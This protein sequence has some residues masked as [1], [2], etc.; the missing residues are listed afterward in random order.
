[1]SLLYGCS[2]PKTVDNKIKVEK[3]I[4]EW[5]LLNA[6][7][8][9]S[10]ISDSFSNFTEVDFSVSSDTPERY[11]RITH[12]YKLKS[13]DN[14]EMK[15][16]HFFVIN[17]DFKVAIISSNETAM[18]QSVPPSV[19]EW[20]ITFGEK[21]K[22]IDYGGLDTSYYFKKFKDYKNIGRNLW[23]D[24][25]YLDDD[26]FSLLLKSLKNYPNRGMKIKRIINAVPEFETEFNKL[27]NELNDLGM[28]LY[29]TYG[30]NPQTNFAVIQMNNDTSEIYTVANFDETKKELH[31]KESNGNNIFTYS[32]DTSYI[33][34]NC[35]NY[36]LKYGK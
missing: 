22:N 28:D 26:C 25:L 20:S 27:G 23:R 24:F 14:R 5:I 9:D 32:L 13:K 21:F 36:I 4:T 18:L 11:Y 8:P 35:F 12:S 33:S 17:K 2:S 1:L 6:D 34:T 31:F 16:K 15:N 29:K 10:Y 3:T 30:K 7:F 19:F